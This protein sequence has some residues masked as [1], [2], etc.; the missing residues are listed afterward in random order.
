M[1]CDIIVLDVHAGFPREIMFLTNGMR[2]NCYWYACWF[3]R[4]KIMFWWMGCDVYMFTVM[5]DI[6]FF[7]WFVLFEDLRVW[8][9]GMK[10]LSQVHASFC[11]VLIGSMDGWWVIVGCGWWI[12]VGCECWIM[13]VVYAHH[14]CLCSLLFVV[15]FSF[16]LLN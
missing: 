13:N 16:I 6:V 3:F 10:F 15:N 9:S 7:I 2:Y 12:I 4:K 1:G 5:N 8:I 11:A 14:V